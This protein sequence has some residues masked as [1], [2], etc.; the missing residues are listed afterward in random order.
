MIEGTISEL[1]DQLEVGM[2]IEHNGDLR[3]TTTYPRHAKIGSINARE[4]REEGGYCVD[5]H[6]SGW[7]KFEPRINALSSKFILCDKK[8][9]KIVAYATDNEHLMVEINKFGTEVD[10]FSLKKMDI[11]YA[12]VEL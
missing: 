6:S 2:E 9:G 11:K 12:V 3:G 5:R 1:W 10:V 4:F 7:I 8:T